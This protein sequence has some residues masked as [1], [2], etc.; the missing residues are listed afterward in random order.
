MQ[1]KELKHEFELERVILF[2]DAVF[3]IIITI[4]VLELRLPEGLYKPKA[5][6]TSKILIDLWP[7]FVAYALSFFLVSMFWVRHLKVFKTL[8]DYD[9]PLVARNL[10]FLFF[11]SL[12][13]FAVSMLTGTLSP[14]NY[15]SFDVYIAVIL[16]ATFAQTNIIQYM[17]K[18]KQRLCFSPE[19]V[20]DTL[21]WKVQKLNFILIPISIA[22][23]VVMNFT[24]MVQ[25]VP[26]IVM[27][28][29]I[30]LKRTQRKYYPK[31]EQ[32]KKLHSD[33]T[34]NDESMVALQE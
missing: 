30:I 29:V 11:I 24:G 5:E 8:R 1:D 10:I 7:K 28:Q 21:Q 3:A 15:Y 13:P 18:H 20:E 33:K 14:K 6:E 12:F 25:F 27:L 31:K 32:A 19:K 9:V 17:V 26:Y 22:L 4:M 2:S 34:G 16:I 23:M